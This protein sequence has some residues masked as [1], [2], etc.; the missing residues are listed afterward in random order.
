M[1]TRTEI[2]SSDSCGPARRLGPPPDGLAFYRSAIMHESCPSSGPTRP[3]GQVNH[4]PA[5]RDS[6]LL[7]RLRRATAYLHYRVGAETW[8]NPRAAVIS[9]PKS[10]RTWLRLMLDQLGIGGVRFSHAGSTEEASITSRRLR[11]GVRWWNGKR[12][13]L[14]IR[15]PRDT[16]VS[17]Y[18]QAT[19]RSHVYSGKLGDFLRD[20]RFGIE[21]IIQFDLLWLRERRVSPP[22]SAQLRGPA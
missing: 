15:D 3:A 12:V 21:R 7:L 11:H 14:L 10:G 1:P 16:A 4:P 18:F 6:P 13:L 9:H 22:S 17:F 5:L 2:A 8:L 20:P 19:R